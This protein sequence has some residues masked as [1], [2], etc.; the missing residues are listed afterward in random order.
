LR[1]QSRNSDTT[2]LSGIQRR[3]C[4]SHCDGEQRPRDA[5]ALSS[6][7]LIVRTASSRIKI[8]FLYQCVYHRDQG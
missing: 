8:R 6:M 4:S 5:T 3:D 1:R 7:T 2:A